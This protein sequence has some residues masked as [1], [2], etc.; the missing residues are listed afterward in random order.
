MMMITYPLQILPNTLRNTTSGDEY[1]NYLL[2]IAQYNSLWVLF[3]Q[4][5]PNE[6]TSLNEWQKKNL[7]Q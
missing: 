6:S 4:R 1:S 3:P 2:P 5:I 7:K